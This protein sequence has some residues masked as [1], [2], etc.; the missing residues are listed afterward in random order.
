MSQLNDPRATTLDD[1]KQLGLWA[2][3]GRRVMIYRKV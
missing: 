1:V 3:L 2:A